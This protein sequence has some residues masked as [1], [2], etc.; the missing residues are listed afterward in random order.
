M[1]V[2]ELMSC[3]L[4]KHVRLN[5]PCSDI[6]LF[7]TVKNFMAWHIQELSILSIHNSET[8]AVI[9]S[10]TI[11]GPTGHH[12]PRSSPLPLICTVPSASANFL[13]ATWK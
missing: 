10:K 5:L 7:P 1:L 13:N 4:G 12:H 11:F 6:W 2:E 9:W 8:G 3:H